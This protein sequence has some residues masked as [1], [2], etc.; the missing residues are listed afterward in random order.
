[1]LPQRQ[2]AAALAGVIAGTDGSVVKQY[3]LRRGEAPGGSVHKSEYRPY[4]RQRAER[5]SE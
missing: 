5:R 2:G 3:R 1:V 4:V